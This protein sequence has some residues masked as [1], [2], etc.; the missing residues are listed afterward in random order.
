MVHKPF[1]KVTELFLKVV[2]WMLSIPIT[3]EQNSTTP[4]QQSLNTQ[5]YNNSLQ[6]NE[7]S[8]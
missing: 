5:K 3:N 2:G 1:F 6:Q 4:K 8:K 7:N